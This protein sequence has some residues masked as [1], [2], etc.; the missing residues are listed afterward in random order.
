MEHAAAHVGTD[1]LE[2]VGAPRTYHEVVAQLVAVGARV[3]PDV[4]EWD[5]VQLDPDM[6]AALRTRRVRRRVPSRSSR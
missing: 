2:A 6:L 4:I 5:Q 3:T 1:R